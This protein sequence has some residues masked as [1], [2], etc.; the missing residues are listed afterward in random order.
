MGQSTGP[1]LESEVQL[2]EDEWNGQKIA[3]SRMWIRSKKK[4]KEKRG[5]R[6]ASSVLPTPTIFH[7]HECLESANYSTDCTLALYQS[8][9][10]IKGQGKCI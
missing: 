10:I 1:K 6:A 4:K 3:R 2:F 5:N 8:T 7:S 9:I